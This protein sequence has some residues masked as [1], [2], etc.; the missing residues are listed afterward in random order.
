MFQNHL[1]QLLTLVAMEPPARASAKALRDEKVKVLRLGA[2]T[3]TRRQRSLRP[4]SRLSPG[5]GRRP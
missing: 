5:A 2:A 1:M 3:A 4:V